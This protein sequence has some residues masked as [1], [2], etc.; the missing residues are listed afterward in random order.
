MT[1]GDQ[2]RPTADTPVASQAVAGNDGAAQPAGP[3]KRRLAAGTWV[4]SSIY[5]LF[6]LFLVSF[7]VGAARHHEWNTVS[8]EVLVLLLFLVVPTGGMKWLHRAR[9]SR[10]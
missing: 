4:G 5:L 8:G 6:L 10:K 7:V 1:G 2:R 9:K 3:F